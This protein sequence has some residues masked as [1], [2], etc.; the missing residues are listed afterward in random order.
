MVPVQNRM[1]PTLSHGAVSRTTRIQCILTGFRQS[2]NTPEQCQSALSCAAT[3]KGLR[4]DGSVTK[5]RWAP[6]TILESLRRRYL[7]Q[8]S[9]TL[10]ENPDFKGCLPLRPKQ[11][12]LKHKFTATCATARLVQSMDT[13]QL[14]KR[15]ALRVRD[16]VRVRFV[17]RIPTPTEGRRDREDW[18]LAMGGP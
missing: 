7:S 15:K 17:G 14:V 10:S 13:S 6:K 16:G 9:K 4:A 18:F 3:E 2:Q 12:I 8:P 11:P 5:P 1:A